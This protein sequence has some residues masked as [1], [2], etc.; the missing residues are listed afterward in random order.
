MSQ[1]KYSWTDRL[2]IGADEALRTLNNT[3]PANRPSPALGQQEHSLSEIERAHAAAL[4]RVNHAGEVCAQALY[5][6]QAISS[7]DPLL[8]EQLAQAAAEEADHLAW[9][10]QR[11][12]DLNEDVSRLNFLWYVCSWTLGAGAGL[13][14]KKINLG[15]LA[16]TEQ[17]VSRH[18]SEHL[19][20]LPNTDKKSRAIVAQMLK[21]ETA[22]AG[23]AM[24]SGGIAF[25]K[26]I[27]GAMYTI[28]RI[29]VF[30]SY[31]I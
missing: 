30:A 12:D 20:Q 10:A 3:L 26:R 16:A 11:I 22:H 9:C 27:T 17:Q 23:H 29:M 4:M 2:L 15:F 31:R 6:G 21:E 25:D 24:D 19:A 8:Q 28:S 7:R 13:M 18:L 5:R 14:G 1:R